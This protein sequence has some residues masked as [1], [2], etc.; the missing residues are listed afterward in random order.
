[1][2]VNC[3]SVIQIKSLRLYTTTEVIKQMRAIV[4][5]KIVVEVA[6]A[7]MGVDLVASARAAFAVD[8]S[9][10]ISG[11]ALVV[12]DAEL[13]ANKSLSALGIKDGSSVQIRYVI[14]S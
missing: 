3:A 1:M 8:P 10:A 11:M 5:K 6:D 9:I 14:T 2:K 7:A 12:N 13:D 4:G